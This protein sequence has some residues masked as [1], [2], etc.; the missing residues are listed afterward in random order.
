MTGYFAIVR[1]SAR[2]VRVFSVTAHVLPS[3]VFGVSVVSTS[4]GSLGLH[5]R[6]HPETLGFRVDATVGRNTRHTPRILACREMAPFLDGRRVDGRIYK[7]VS[8]R[9]P[10]IGQP[11]PADRALRALR[12]CWW[13]SRHYQLPPAVSAS[14]NVQGPHM[15][16]A[17]TIGLAP[18]TSHL[19]PQSGFVSGFC[20][21]FLIGSFCCVMIPL[22][23]RLQK[24]RLQTFIPLSHCFS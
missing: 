9:Q 17:G 19:P 14:P 21:G 5:R 10:R 8:C 24:S 13:L 12:L 22:S 3:F 1:A 7:S 4:G 6:S 23:S 2:A 18:H 20:F 16:V 15:P 11:L